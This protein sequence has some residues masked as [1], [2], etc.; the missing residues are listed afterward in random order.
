MIKQVPL[1]E[2]NR[3]IQELLHA[4]INMLFEE[5]YPRGACLPSIFGNNRT[6]MCNKYDCNCATCREEF[7]AAYKRQQEAKYLFKGYE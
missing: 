5:T 1:E 4:K 3:R 6:A 7:I 2:A